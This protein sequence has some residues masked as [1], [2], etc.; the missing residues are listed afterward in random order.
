MFDE[1]RSISFVVPKEKD[2]DKEK[3]LTPI[4]DTIKEL[5]SGKGYAIGDIYSR[6]G[7]NDVYSCDSKLCDNPLQI[8]RYEPSSVF[9]CH[10]P[11][12]AY[13]RARVENLPR[14]EYKNFITTTNE[15]IRKALQQVGYVDDPV[16]AATGLIT[17]K[18]LYWCLGR[19]RL[20][21]K[22]NIRA[23]R[24]IQRFLEINITGFESKYPQERLLIRSLEAEES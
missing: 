13:D 22:R 21:K 12:Y 15:L 18:F 20:T 16:R 3:S 14:E 6:K 8:I 10:L 9:C 7:G 5:L 2:A 17:L 23:Y 24:S 11:Y 4:L 19:L 1:L